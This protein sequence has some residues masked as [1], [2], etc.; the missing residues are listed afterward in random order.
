[1]KEQLGRQQEEELQR[2]RTQRYAEYLSASQTWAAASPRL[3]TPPSQ[4]Q[5]QTLSRH[6]EE[7]ARRA[8][9]LTDGQAF[10]LGK[11]LG[12]SATR[13]ILDGTAGEFVARAEGPAPGEALAAQLLARDAADEQIARDA[14]D[15]APIVVHDEAA[16]IDVAYDPSGGAPEVDLKQV[17]EAMGAGRPLDAE[18]REYME[19]RFGLNLGNVRIHTGPKADALSKALMA[20]AFALG[21]DVTFAAG[22]YKPGT[23]EGDFL[24]AHELTH[25]VQAGEA[26]EKP[27][28]SS[29][30]S[31]PDDAIEVEADQVAGEV[32]SV[33]RAEFARAKREAAADGTPVETKAAPSP[34]ARKAARLEAMPK[35]ARIG[36][37]MPDA[38][39]R[40]VRQA[41]KEL[42]RKRTKAETIASAQKLA[43]STSMM[44]R[45]NTLPGPALK[46]VSKV[47]T[48]ARGAVTFLGKDVS[49]DTVE[50]IGER[51]ED[52]AEFLNG[53]IAEKGLWLE[54]EAKAGR[55]NAVAG[56]VQTF[57]VN[58]VLNDYASAAETAQQLAKLLGDDVTLLYN[59]SEGAVSDLVQCAEQK[60]APKMPQGEVEHVRSRLYGILARSEAPTIHVVAHSQGTMMVAKAL[61]GLV[62]NFS[63]PEMFQRIADGAAP[64]GDAGA[65]GYAAT[66]KVVRSQLKGILGNTPKGEENFAQEMMAGAMASVWAKKY[67]NRKVRVTALGGAASNSQWPEW[68]NN[69]HRVDH[70]SDIVAT[71]TSDAKMAHMITEVLRSKGIAT[72]SEKNAGIGREHTLLDNSNPGLDPMAPHYVTNYLKQ[73]ETIKALAEVYVRVKGGNSTGGLMVQK[74]AESAGSGDALAAA[75]AG[76]ESPSGSLPFASRIQEL[77]GA[78]DISGITAHTGPAAAEAGKAMGATAYATGTDVVFAKTPDLHTAA[79]EAAHV[80][81]QAH[82]VSLPGGVG[83]P[84]DRYELHADAVADAV[85]RGD[86]AEP[87]LDSF[88]GRASG[89]ARGV[90]AKAAPVQMNG[91]GEGPVISID[92]TFLSP[93]SLQ[94]KTMKPSVLTSYD[95]A[96]TLAGDAWTFV[97]SI[98]QWVDSKDPYYTKLMDVADALDG[99][100]IAWGGDTDRL[101][102]SDGKALS[103]L[104]ASAEK[105]VYDFSTDLSNC[106]IGATWDFPK[107]KIS[108]QGDLVLIKQKDVAS[109]AKRVMA[110]LNP[111]L[112]LLETGP[113]K[114]VAP[115]QAEI[116]AWTKIQTDF[117]GS[118]LFTI[119]GTFAPVIT[120]W[121]STEKLLEELEAL[122]VRGQTIKMGKQFKFNGTYDVSTYDAAAGFVS[123]VGAELFFRTSDLFPSDEKPAHRYAKS[124]DDWRD[125]WD[126]FTDATSGWGKAAGNWEL[127][128][129]D[130]QAKEID[131][132][133]KHLEKRL[134]WMQ[135]AF[136]LDLKEAKAGLRKA[137]REAKAAEKAAQ[138]AMRA[139]FLSNASNADIAFAGQTIDGLANLA[140]EINTAHQAL[141]GW[142]GGSPG[143][144]LKS[145]LPGLLGKG[146]S[147]ANI[148]VDWS[149]ET[150]MT[151]GSGFEGMAAL[152]NTMSVAGLVMTPTMSLFTAHI[153]PMLKAITALMGKLQVELIK[154]N[155]LAAE[156]GMDGQYYPGADPGGEPMWIFM[157]AVMHSGGPGGV[158]SPPGSV[159]D[160]FESFAD[161][162]GAAAKKSVPMDDGVLGTGF[163]KNLDVKS[164]KA[165]VYNHRETVW[166]C[167]YGSRK[168]PTQKKGAD[169]PSE[170]VVQAAAARGIAG[171]GGPLPHGD[172]IQESFGRHDVSGVKAHTGPDATAA[173]KD[174]GA[175]A[176]ATGTDVAF[177]G[178]PDLHTAAHEAAHVVQQRHGV[179]LK[180]E[181][182]RAGDKYEQHADAVADAVVRGE[183]A[184]PLLD[185][186]VG[187]GS[188]AGGV[189]AKAVQRDGEVE[190][191][192][193]PDP[194]VQTEGNIDVQGGDGPPPVDTTV[195]NQS[196]EP[197]DG[198]FDS[199]TPGGAS[200][201]G[202]PTPSNPTPAPVSTPT[203]N[204]TQAGDATINPGL[205]SPQGTSIPAAEQL[206]QATLGADP[207]SFQ[208][209]IEA[210]IAQ[211][212]T[213]LTGAQSQVRATA[214]SLGDSLQ[215]EAEGHVGAIQT[216]ASSAAASVSTA[217][218]DA[219][220]AATAAAEAARGQV[221]VYTESAKAEIEAAGASAIQRA[222]QALSEAAS[223]YTAEVEGVIS[224]AEAE[225]TNTVA[226]MRQS[227]Q[228]AAA[229][230]RSVAEEW[231]TKYAGRTGVTDLDAKRAKARADAARSVGQSTAEELIEKANTAADEFAGLHAQ[232]RPTIETLLQPVLDQLAQQSADIAGTVA[233]TTASLLTQADE[234]GVPVKQSIDDAEAAALTALDDQERAMLQLVED[235]A[236]A[237]EEQLLAAAEAGRT[238]REEAGEGRAEALAAEAAAL[239]QQ[240]A[241]QDA[242]ASGDLSEEIEALI[243]QILDNDAAQ[244]LDDLYRELSGNLAALASQGVQSLDQLVAAAIDLANRFVSQFS[245]GL[246]QSLEQLAS[247]LSD[248][249]S[250]AL[251]QFD[252]LVTQV[253]AAA[254][255]VIRRAREEM[256]G[257][258][259]ELLGDL[260]QAAT[261]L[262]DVLQE[263]LGKLPAQIKEE[264]D[265]AAGKI[266]SGFWGR[267]G[268][269]LLVIVCVVA[270]VALVIFAGPALLGALG[271][272]AGGLLAK[273]LLGAAIGFIAGAAFV[274]FKDAFSGTFSITNWRE[275]LKGGIVGAVT[276]AITVL[277][278][279]MSV[280]A[281]GAL[282]GL[283]DYFTNLAMNQMDWLDGVGQGFFKDFSLLDLGIT[284]V[285]NMGLNRIM[286]GA[287]GK[288]GLGGKIA[289]F[290]RGKMPSWNSFQSLVGQH[291]NPVLRDSGLKALNSTFISA[292]RRVPEQLTSKWL[293]GSIKDAVKAGAGWLKDTFL[294]FFPDEQPQ[295]QAAQ[296]GSVQ[297]A[298]GPGGKQP[299]VDVHTEAA[300]GTSGAGG[301]LPYG[302]QIQ[303]SFGKHDVS[304][305]KAHTGAGPT[306]AA[307][308]IGAAA[309]ATG[310]D[311]AFAGTP[312]LH[313]AAH[314]AAHVVQQAHGVSLAGGV[315]KAGDKYETHADA[316]ADAV[317]AGR[318]AEPLLDAFTGG[319]SAGTHSGI[320]KRA[321]QLDGGDEDREPEAGELSAA[322]EIASTQQQGESQGQ[323]NDA[324]TPPVGPN[325]DM[326]Q[327][328]PATPGPGQDELMCLDPSAV[329]TPISTP[330]DPNAPPGPRPSDAALD[331][332]GP[333]HNDP[334][335]AAENL[336]GTTWGFMANCFGPL[337]GYNSD[338]GGFA[339]D[340][341]WGVGAG[342]DKIMDAAT[343]DRGEGALATTIKVLDTLRAVSETVLSVSSAIGLTCGILS[344]IGL[345]PPL[346]PVGAAL[347]SVAGIC[348][349]ISFWAGIA[350]TAFALLTSILSA[351][352]LV[353]AIKDGA[354]NVADLYAQYQQDVGA[355]VADGIG[356]LMVLGVKGITKGMTRANGYG[357]GMKGWS[358]ALG[359]SDGRVAR[360][361]AYQGL[362]SLGQAG[363][364]TGITLST[365]GTT[366]AMLQSTLQGQLARAGGEML[367]KSALTRIA[368]SDIKGRFADNTAR[369]A[370]AIRGCKASESTSASITADLAATVEAHLA[371]TP[372]Q[373]DPQHVPAPE[374]GRNELEELAGRR[375]EIAAAR[376][377]VDA[378]R[379]EGQTAIEGGQQLQVAADQHEAH[380]SALD[381]QVAGHQEGLGVMHADAQRGIDETNKGAS[382]VG[383]LKGE[384]NS[385]QSDADA[386]NAEAGAASMPKPKKS[387]SWFDRV[388]NWFQEK[389]FSKVGAALDAIRDFVADIILK[390]VA[391][392][393]GVDD[394]DS[395]LA[396][397][398]EALAIAQGRTTDTQGRATEVSGEAARAH[399]DAATASADAS[400]AISEGQAAVGQADA[401][402][403]QLM[404][405]DSQLAS[406]E[407]EV[408]SCTQAWQEEYGEC[409]DEAYEGGPE[410][411]PEVLSWLEAAADTTATGLDQLEGD[412][413]QAASQATAALMSDSAQSGIDLG[414]IATAIEGDYNALVGRNDGRRSQLASLAAE[415][416]GLSG[417]RYA[418]VADQIT[419]IGGD[420]SRIAGEADADALAFEALVNE[421]MT[422]AAG[423]LAAAADALQSSSNT[424]DLQKKDAAGPAAPP[425]PEP[426]PAPV[427]LMPAGEP[428]VQMAGGG[429]ARTALKAEQKD[430]LKRMQRIV[431]K[432]PK[433]IQKRRVWGLIKEVLINWDAHLSAD[434]KPL[435][436]W[437]REAAALIQSVT[438]G[439][440]TPL[441]DYPASTGKIRKKDLKKASKLL[442]NPKYVG[443]DPNA[444]GDAGD[445]GVQQKASSGGGG[446]MDVHAAAAAGTSGGGGKLPHAAKI[447]ESFGRHDVGGI[448]AHT[449]GQ[450][451]AAAKSMGARAYAT[452]NDVAFASGGADLHT[453]AHEAA[454]VAQQRSGVSLSGG[455]GKAGDKYEQHADAVADAVVAGKSAEPILDKMA[456]G[457]SAA[458]VQKS[459]TEELQ[460]KAS[461]AFG[462][463]ASYDVVVQLAPR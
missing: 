368:I 403:A 284:V 208:A 426:A 262:A 202:G 179:S 237:I 49:E 445:A 57:F 406:E 148:I 104:L 152:E 194:D 81:Q 72:D 401:L 213:A 125:E 218:A 447:Q 225:A 190:Q 357:D 252:D 120:A 18:T 347:A 396:E 170:E 453:A 239:Q 276:G 265:K 39:D 177:A 205:S 400:T 414:G 254:E 354:D 322:D 130:Q 355:F 302:S 461:G 351:I 195:P 275:Y 137:E 121:D 182:G 436:K 193:V 261:G 184:E 88:V 316:V 219:R 147:V 349:T 345:F 402:D 212:G 126:K 157:T 339:F 391:F 90:Q 185:A 380:A 387:T 450:A 98:V 325:P 73:P 352:Q 234:T 78:H 452:G 221:D 180:G 411:D 251:G 360:G 386:K 323:G 36:P 286:R 95:D 89:R 176:Y 25:V 245:E 24:L 105:V 33:G 460:L 373:P 456:G 2:K 455:V 369:D 114:H 236:G 163:F 255:A 244:A 416:Q 206:F 371:S 173:A 5:T 334:S 382:E 44:L 67:I 32:V 249:V 274:A 378:Q 20:H 144:F 333:A 319:V 409:V 41:M 272:A 310:S 66:V 54:S 55:K 109:L 69:L 329:E 229:Q 230:A 317:V 449:G 288:S 256:G 358:S 348:G 320:Q 138:D 31:E 293:K 92:S 112:T 379:I 22:Q 287:D 235:T 247:T 29:S 394:I 437:V 154:L 313:T 430:V 412:A 134:G 315:G 77:F 52:A 248:F 306:S 241:G 327:P 58:G 420:L 364:G 124:Y 346:A 289:N 374:R 238:A 101:N 149:S 330:L 243:Q 65:E 199:T 270:L 341:L 399:S 21:A 61:E 196:I 174:M 381:E 140:V 215:S 106:W 142:T 19:W 431:G 307:H 160:Y 366:R 404:S 70:G 269:V 211:I 217:F 40:Q 38:T 192:T 167:L 434:L 350:A 422:E 297:N 71:G 79:H 187:S 279:G 128:I 107:L 172:R 457:G 311:V 60:V 151:K 337:I 42:N 440:L 278:G 296:S 75:V 201:S 47:N 314:E 175:R 428:V 441:F 203:G 183:S 116:K 62:E 299:D 27:R 439:P 375:S 263:A 259:D 294:S 162:F 273:V 376:A 171:S 384:T 26:T 15:E 295:R 385:L 9:S 45:D 280:W 328:A 153:G 141:G 312:D 309:F 353:S 14:A 222:Q 454:H 398:Q 268:A 451:D 321:V 113:S 10:D 169:G 365:A 161:K 427:Q 231:A 331:G 53:Y 165:W 459:E 158:P 87:L 35:A 446:G 12:N 397:E 80:V 332:A 68:F 253:M 277:T 367:L 48:L 338:R 429:D 43:K 84:G 4:D 220:A 318:S 34:T 290:F 16:G 250:G 388:A 115:L 266:K 423:I 370:D 232:V 94:D 458:G 226:A 181:V 207:N 197:S 372:N 129:S 223:N 418:L 257:Q 242:P 462:G 224:S 419:R 405:L 393:M 240:L 37:G 285:L 267:L 30:V 145:E 408:L 389:V 186:F 425:A 377:H 410:V 343:K 214:T 390:V 23:K 8:W 143:W 258:V 7:E 444:G 136:K 93:W 292:L 139:A 133:V 3:P 362:Q 100:M 164:F 168:V 118:D 291:I 74:R 363:A 433:K 326:S 102:M 282:M 46:V 383:N 50:D 228:D 336:L 271:I 264:A 103:K 86:S 300:K 435:P 246:S 308:A 83:S 204:V 56:D 76:L 438:H 117:A 442:K 188:G 191:E 216:A 304:G 63:S 415:V 132:Q 110:R 335:M 303:K 463:R 198:S 448:R 82:G 96:S 210:G 111:I 424:S 359:A 324:P 1:M 13:S 28:K 356:V 413:A 227:G 155:D 344:L 97:D 421:A 85:V 99:K 59:P 432:D 150:T 189:Q 209:Q 135:D 298:P 395:K 283:R 159:V 233:E 91:G 392:F 340:N 178:T 305:I 260:R 156:M 342:V 166:S 131:K 119:G 301:P 51:I 123:D 200:V 443:K 6:R 17:Q 407:E 11:G 417:A 146:V 361:A 281:Q 64:S 122:P 108:L 127:P